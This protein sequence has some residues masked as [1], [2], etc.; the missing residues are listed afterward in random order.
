MNI[1]KIIENEI[2]Y[3][4]NNEDY[5]NQNEAECFYDFVSLMPSLI[6]LELDDTTNCVSLEN[7]QDVFNSNDSEPIDLTKISV[8]VTALGLILLCRLQ[9]ISLSEYL[10]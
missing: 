6:P 9:N 2:R 8:A 7:I 1:P 4:L 10:D 5:K 3:Y